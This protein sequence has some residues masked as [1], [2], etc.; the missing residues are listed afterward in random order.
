MKKILSVFLVLALTAGSFFLGRFTAPE[1]SSQTF[2]AVITQKSG[3]HLIVEGIPE[4]DINHRWSFRF[5]MEE[6]VPIL[7][8]GVELTL[9]DLD[10]GDL[11]AVTYSGSVMEIS[12]AIIQN[13]LKIQ[14]LEDQR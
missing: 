9:D 7:W 12:P 5:T 3:S 10:E 8:R 11:I 4:N 2:Y 6:K 14:L 13:I 1:Q